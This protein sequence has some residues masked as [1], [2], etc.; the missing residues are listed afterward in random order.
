MWPAA[1]AGVGLTSPITMPPDIT[2][3]GNRNPGMLP[4]NG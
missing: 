4:I 3:D 2:R 1:F